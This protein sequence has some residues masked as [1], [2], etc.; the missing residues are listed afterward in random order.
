MAAPPP[1]L[2]WLASRG[3]YISPKLDLFSPGAGGDRSVRAAADIAEGERLLLVPEPATLTYA[4]AGGG[5]EAAAVP[6][7]AAWLAEAA[8]AQGGFMR[9]VILM[10][11]EIARGEVR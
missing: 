4:P 9:T 6:A 5:G 2:A 1:F 3:A 10:M 8:P 7:A 11:A